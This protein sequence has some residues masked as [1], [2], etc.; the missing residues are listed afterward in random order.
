MIR[1]NR[2]VAI[3]CLRLHVCTLVFIVPAAGQDGERHDKSRYNLFNSVPVEFM[4][5]LST[6]RP[7]K[8]ESPYTVDAGH[9]QVEMDFASAT[10]DKSDGVATRT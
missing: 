1:L 10:F 5:T 6:D 2:R 3:P 7:D 9:F 4:R 8:T